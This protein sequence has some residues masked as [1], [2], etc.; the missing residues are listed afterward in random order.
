MLWSGGV[1]GSV[2]GRHHCRWFDWPVML[3]DCGTRTLCAKTV[4]ITTTHHFAWRRRLSCLSHRTVLGDQHGLCVWVNAVATTTV[5]PIMWC[6]LQV[7]SRLILPT[8]SSLACFD[9]QGCR[10][11]LI[12]NVESSTLTKVVCK[13][14]MPV[15]FGSLSSVKIY[16]NGA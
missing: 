16:T 10:S 1:G 2:W 5:H 3:V 9:G 14:A 8:T 7:L 15:A 4:A 13:F 12:V 6:V 11:C